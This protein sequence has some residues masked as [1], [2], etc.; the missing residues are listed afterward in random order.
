MMVDFGPGWIVVSNRITYQIAIHPELVNHYQ[1]QLS[2]AVH[3]IYSQSH[4]F[5]DQY[6]AQTHNITT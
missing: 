3:H 2:S 5:D 6:G 4:P 1:V